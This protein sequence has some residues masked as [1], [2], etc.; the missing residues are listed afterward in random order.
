MRYILPLILIVAATAGCRGWTSQDPPVHPNPNMDTQEKHKPYRASDFF[1]DGRSMRTP[2]AGTVPRTVS[3]TESRDAE[4][5]GAD[6]HLYTGVT[7][8]GV[9]PDSL[10]E[11]VEVNAAFLARGEERY[12]IYCAPCHAKPSSWPP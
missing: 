8:D 9:I 11:A 12:N 5:V 4:Y 3:G 6:T 2:P 7:A 10:P 1:A